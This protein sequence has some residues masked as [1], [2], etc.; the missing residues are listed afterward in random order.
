VTTSPHPD[1]HE[2]LVVFAGRDQ[3]DAAERRLEDAGVPRRVIDVDR[4]QDALLSLH[5]EMR[6]ELAESWMLP[7]A[8]VAM[9]KEGARGFVG[10]TALCCVIAVVVAV[11]FAFIDFGMTFWA[12][13]LVL[14]LIALACGGVIGLI[15]GPA[16]AT[17]RPDEPA[18][19]DRGVVM[20]I[21]ADTPAVRQILA[22]V[23][24]IRVDEITG[25]VIP[26]GT[27]QTE[28]PPTVRGTMD[29]VKAGIESDDF[30]RPS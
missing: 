25:G 8:G 21:R 18:A 16:L 7:H 9:T 29:D 1:T 10:I 27:V 28:A 19:A 6:E 26:R 23:R 4:E 17:K 5:A 12:R 3:A 14:G 2:L 30:E 24:P 15:L 13:L 11:P 20:H 22:E